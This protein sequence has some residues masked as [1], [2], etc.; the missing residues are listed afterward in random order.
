MESGSSSDSELKTWLFWAD[1]DF[2]PRNEKIKK[3]LSKKTHLIEGGNVPESYL[4]F[5]D[6]H[7][8]WKISHERWLQQGIAYGW[9]SKIGW[10]DQF[11]NDVLCTFNELKKRHAILIGMITET[12]GLQQYVSRK[13]QRLYR[14]ISPK[15]IDQ[16][17]IKLT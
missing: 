11:E 9:H 7:N 3:L 5:L 13:V 4:T 1:A 2:F 8:S 15:Q 6:H 14:K 10:P 12:P 16:K 17:A